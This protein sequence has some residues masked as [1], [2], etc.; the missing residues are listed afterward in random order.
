MYH[1]AADA[2]RDDKALIE[3]QVRMGPSSSRRLV[4]VRLIFRARRTD[5]LERYQCLVDVTDRFPFLA[6][7]LATVYD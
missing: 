6:S 2:Q 1:L 5:V 7:P 4:A 3:V